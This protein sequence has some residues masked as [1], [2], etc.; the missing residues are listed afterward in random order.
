MNS[1]LRF[2]FS[3]RLYPQQ[4]IYSFNPVTFSTF[5][6]YLAHSNTLSI[7]ES[8]QFILLFFSL[9]Q[10]DPSI[11]SNANSHIFLDC[12]VYFILKNIR[13]IIF[14]I[15]LILI[16]SILSHLYSGSFYAFLPL[17]SI[18]YTLHDPHLFSLNPIFPVHPCLSGRF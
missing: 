11:F 2:H 7:V 17:F 10:I 9:F 5:A 13:Y 8:R 3:L 6:V 16:Y 18:L 15:Y 4:F 14:V 1:K 12:P